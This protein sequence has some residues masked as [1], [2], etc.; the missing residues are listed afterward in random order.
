MGKMGGAEL[1]SALC[2]CPWI[3]LA[4]GFDSPMQGGTCVH[5]PFFLS[6]PVHI[7]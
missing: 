5:V 1:S 4:M 3:M 2:S 6:I 7:L